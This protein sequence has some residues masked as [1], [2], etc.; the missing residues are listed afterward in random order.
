[1]KT[2]QQNG[3]FTHFSSKFPSNIYSIL[4]ARIS[5]LHSLP[6]NTNSSHIL[7]YTYNMYKI[8]I[9]ILSINVEAAEPITL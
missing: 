6:Q 8:Y 5:L 7:H 4:F 2:V 1:M 9:N 3:R